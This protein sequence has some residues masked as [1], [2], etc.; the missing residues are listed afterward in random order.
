MAEASGWRHQTVTAHPV[1]QFRCP[2]CNWLQLVATPGGPPVAECP[3]CGWS[4]AGGAF[5]AL[6]CPTH[7]AVVV[8]I[9]EAGNEGGGIHSDDIADV[10]CPHCRRPDG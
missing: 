9:P 2:E 7:G 4:E 1:L 6:N 10:C 8:V 5:A 3:W